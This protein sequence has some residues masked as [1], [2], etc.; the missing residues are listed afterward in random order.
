MDPRSRDPG[1]K[2]RLALG[3]YAAAV[4]AATLIHV[5]WLLALALT[6]ALALA[7]AARWRLL[8][9][10]V[11]A[12]LA[13]NLTVSAGYAAIA[14]WQGTLSPDYLLLVNSRVLLMVFL[15]FWFVSRVDILAAVSFSPALSFLVTLAVGQARTLGR[16]VRDFQFAF[17]S[18][19]P[20]RPRPGDRFH[21]AAAQARHLLDRSIHAADETALAMR[22]RGCFDD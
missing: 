2:A 5:W 9:R 15:G 4:V 11:L 16:Q 20:R 22:S 18:R 17:A 12:V 3:A 6:L 19:N 7:G 14:A 1:L 10:T 8:R 21:H 13:F